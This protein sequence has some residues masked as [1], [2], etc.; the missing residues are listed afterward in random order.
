MM[1]SSHT[2]HTFARQERTFIII[3][4]PDGVESCPKKVKAILQLGAPDNKQELQSFL[5]LVNFMSNFI[6]NLAQKTVCMRG[7]L[8]KDV[9]C[10]WT[11]E[12]QTEFDSVKAGIS[13]AMKL[14]HFDPVKQVVIETDAS[15]KGLGAV[16][17]QDG[18]PVKF[19][20]KSL[21]DTES[22][23]SNIER[24]LLAVLFA[25]EKL[26]VYVF[27]RRAPRR[28]QAGSVLPPIGNICIYIFFV[29][30]V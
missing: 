12:M 8:K 22:E 20:S 3:I 28:R 13:Q 10:T 23:Y 15:L 14:T 29:L 9:R 2:R 17:L 7:L 27:G 4:S 30:P 5:W 16:L 11:A 26:H 19:L 18:C 6:P 24:E 25:C 1:E 21:T